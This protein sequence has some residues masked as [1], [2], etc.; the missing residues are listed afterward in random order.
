MKKLTTQEWIAKAI[1]VHGDTYDYSKVVYINSITKVTIGCKIH[2]YFQTLPAQHLLKTG[3]K[4]CNINSRFDTEATFLSKAKKVHG[5]RYDYSETIYTTAKSDI[6]IICK[7]HGK[8]IQKAIHHTQGKNCPKCANILKGKANLKTT[9]TFVAEATKLHNSLYSYSNTKYTGSNNNVEI[10]CSIHGSFF[11]I[12]H[13]HLKGQGCPY[14]AEI[15]NQSCKTKKLTRIYYIKIIQ[16]HLETPVYK[17]GIT[18][19]NKIAQRMKSYLK[20]EDYEVLWL[21]DYMNRHLAVTEE[22]RILA[23]NKQYKYTNS[24]II[25]PNGK[26]F[27]SKEF[28]IKDIRKYNASSPI[29]N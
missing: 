11:Q 20:K 5:D 25:R 3:C 9:E 24:K 8:F 14:C 10:V 16:P 12:P 29:S 2:G 6:I 21:S 15:H 19:K 13:G 7:E 4:Q 28:F 22:Q 18:S 23:K 27:V 26:I 1:A 17:I